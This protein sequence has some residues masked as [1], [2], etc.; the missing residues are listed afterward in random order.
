MADIIQIAGVVLRDQAG[1]YLLVQEKKSTV[2]GL[3][4][5]PA[6][7]VDAGETPQLA[8]IRETQEE[9]GFTVELTDAEPIFIDSSEESGRIKYAF[10]AHASEGKL[11]IP[12]EE[13]LDARWF[14]FR[15]III[16]HKEKKTRSPWVI[17]AITKAHNL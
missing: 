5:L 13:L 3:W 14:E 11:V 17:N 10:L 1:R 15:E 7:H 4:N 16:L 6:G 12:K 9:T 8:A 2:Y